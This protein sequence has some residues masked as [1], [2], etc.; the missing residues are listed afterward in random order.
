M[1]GIE[2]EQNTRVTTQPSPQPL[3]GAL[4][5]RAGEVAQLLRVHTALIEDLSLVPS[6]HM[7]QPDQR[8]LW[9]P[10]QTHG[11]TQK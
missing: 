8:P 3:P 10:T 2:L 1:L 4:S 7:G 9:L 5:L 11:H 6:T